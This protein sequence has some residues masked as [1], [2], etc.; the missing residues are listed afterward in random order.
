MLRYLI[1]ITILKTNISLAPN[2]EEPVIE[3]IKDKYFIAYFC[4]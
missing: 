4:I 2:P 3:F 1:S